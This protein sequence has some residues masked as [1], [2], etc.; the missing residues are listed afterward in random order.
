L[1][2]RLALPGAHRVSQ[3]HSFDVL[4]RFNAASEGRPGSP[5]HAQIE[6]EPAARRGSGFRKLQEMSAVLAPF[7]KLR[8]AATFLVAGETFWSARRYRGRKRSDHEGDVACG[9]SSEPV[10]R[11]SRQALGRDRNSSRPP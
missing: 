8:S 4:P 1:T 6:R 10:R 3:L 9:G 2:P 7:R 11:R 5:A